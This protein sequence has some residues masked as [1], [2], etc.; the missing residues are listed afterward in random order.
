MA[1]GKLSRTL[2]RLQKSIITYDSYLIK[3]SDIATPVKITRQPSAGVEYR[4]ATPA[5]MDSFLDEDGEPQDQ[6]EREKALARL[7]RGDICIIGIY[8]GQLINYGWTSFRQADLVEGVSLILGPGWS[9]GYKGYTVR[10]FRNKGMSR[11]RVRKELSMEYRRSIGIQK[12]L[13][14]VHTRN[15]LTNPYHAESRGR[16]IGLLRRIV[17]LGR[18]RFNWMPRWI[19]AYVAE[20]AV[21]SSPVEVR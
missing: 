11:N 21:S 9:Y 8:E 17:V 6:R 18:W 14:V 2:A 10:G 13:N 19:V 12:S 7:S 20:P 16:A 4:L 15:H 3:E 5:D 1:Q